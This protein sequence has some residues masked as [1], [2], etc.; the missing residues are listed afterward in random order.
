MADPILNL[1]IHPLNT[2]RQDPDW[3]Q[4]LCHIRT[5]TGTLTKF[6]LQSW[7]K[8]RQSAEEWQD[9]IYDQLKGQWNESPGGGYQ[10]S[11]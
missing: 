4:C 5:V 2:A 7:T 9:F 11:C 10:R 8:L 1:D 6:T 3:N